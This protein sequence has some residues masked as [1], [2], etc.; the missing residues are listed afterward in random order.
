MGN[1]NLNIQAVH[2][3]SFYSGVFLFQE[4]EE[5]ISVVPGIVIVE[6]ATTIVAMTEVAGTETAWTI[7]ITTEAVITET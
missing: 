7:V 1:L 3:G 5:A 6:E 2:L 4:T